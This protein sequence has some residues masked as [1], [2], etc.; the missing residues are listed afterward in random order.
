MK[1]LAVAIIIA[2]IVAA[3]LLRRMNRS[4]DARRKAELAARHERLR[5]L[6][7]SRGWS[8]QPF[9]AGRALPFT[10]DRVTS[11][12]TTTGDANDV[13]EGM[14]ASWPFLACQYSCRVGSGD[15]QTVIYKV[16]LALDLGTEIP[17][18]V[19]RPRNTEVFKQLLGSPI[20]TGDEHFDGAYTIDADSPEFARDVLSQPIRALMSQT[21]TDMWSFGGST[22]VLSENGGDVAEKLED[23]MRRAVAI[24]NEIPT[25]VWERLHG[26]G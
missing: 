15:S 20:T 9:G 5:Q 7:T 21:P 23:M 25:P 13:V 24:L 10:T 2:V 12:P 11:A 14:C 17:R 6:A 4:L 8:H 26:E 16:V 18:L 3:L 1:F 22:L 19:L